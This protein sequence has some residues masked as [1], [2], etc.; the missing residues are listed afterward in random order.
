MKAFVKYGDQAFQA[1]LQD[2][3]DPEPGTREVLLKVA[4]CGICGSDL[5]AYRASAGYEWVTPPVVLGHEFTGTVIAVGPAVQRYQSGDRV[6]VIGIQ[7][8][9][10]CPVCRNGDTNL[11]NRR[12][13][14][15]L[16]LDGGMSEYAVV[17]ED[18]LIP[19]PDTVDLSMAAIAEPL[20]VAAHALSKTPLYP[21]QNVVI[22]GPGPIGL[23][24][25]VIARCSGARVLMVGTN[26]DTQTR[27]PVAQ[28]LG[29][30]VVNVSQDPID[31]AARF[32]FGDR[33][34][35]LWVEASGSPQAFKS[36]LNSVRRGGSLVIVGMF[37]EEFIWFP[38][39]AVRAEHSLYFS[40][41]SAYRDYQ[42]ALDLMAD[43]AIEFTPMVTFSPIQRAQEAFQD[44]DKGKTVKVVL[45]PKKG[46]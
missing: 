37:A 10:T 28:R 7:G 43:G 23:F 15:G 27:L 33:P 2:I 35:D 38:T 20:S 21:G 1:S 11:C 17:G 4:G 16:D 5:H 45:I 31:R 26:P 36:A 46:D 19:V 18:Y 13:V 29:F 39:V 34:P 44:A 6:A 12:K 25:G 42:F 41:A 24:C 14:I 30:T 22:T 40:Y 32:L 3:T 9:G 8:C